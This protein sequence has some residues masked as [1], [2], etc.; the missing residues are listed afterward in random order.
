MGSNGKPDQYIS[1]RSDITLRKEAELELKRHRD[2]LQELVDEQT[3]EVRNSEVLARN[4]LAELEQQK[5]VL[6]QHA[7]VSVSDLAGRITY[8]NDKFTAVCGYSREELIG[9]DHIILNSGHHPKG[10]FRAMY[11]QVS[12]GKIW[13]AEVCNRAKNGCLY[14]V[15]TTIAPF[16]DGAGF[17]KC[18]ISVR[19][20]ITERKRAEATADAARIEAERL[21]RLKSDFLANMSHEIRTPLNA[22]IG[23]SRIGMREDQGRKSLETISRINDASQHLLGV[24]NDILDFSKIE[25]GKLVVESRPLYLPGA[26]GHVIALMGDSL[27]EDIKLEYTLAEDLP[28]WVLGDVLRL[29][30]V[31]FNLLSNAMK[32]SRQGEISLTVERAGEDIVFCVSD[33]GIGMSPEQVDR[34]FCAFEQADSSTTREFGGTGLGLAISRQLARLMGGDISVESALGKGSRFTLR[35]PLPETGMPEHGGD[36]STIGGP[37]LCGLRVLAADDVEINRVILED[38]LLQEGAQTTFASNGQEAVSLVHTR[39]ADAFDVVLMDI[40]MPVMDGFEATRQ[41]HGIAPGL[42][43]IGLTAHAMAEERNKCLACGMVDHVTKPI[44]A[45]LLVAAIVHHGS[46][47]ATDHHGQSC[48]T[49]A[50]PEIS[51][52]PARIDWEALKHR[53]DNRTAFIDRLLATTL[54]FERDIPEKLRKASAEENMRELFSL[55]HGQKGI[56]GNIKAE[57]LEVLSRR[58]EH[59]ARNECDDTRLLAEELAQEIEGLLVLLEDH[60]GL[61]NSRVLE[62]T[63]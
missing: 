60:I 59:S 12:N 50:L 53:Y 7:I 15:D 35:L 52:S 26:A 62:A 46:S 51:K 27:A 30:Q 63:S 28:E 20:D 17:P 21:A 32:F 3:R 40:Q 36:P 25:A 33:T 8:S 48:R 24:I 31:L 22:V 44:D 58:L 14:W 9:Q 1:I 41:I 38:L 37:R 19:T 16:L 11:E 39:G 18:Y 57:A 2:H 13:H 5:F 45:D 43:V 42:P 49:E 23:L 10:F 34:L 4:A 54:K 56:G 47:T 29:N 6:D 55:A 61:A